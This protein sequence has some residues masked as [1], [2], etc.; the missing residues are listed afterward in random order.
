M[1]ILRLKAQL[2]LCSQMLVMLKEVIVQ[3]GC[4]LLYL[5]R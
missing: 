2:A 3:F 4:K 1:Y 5:P